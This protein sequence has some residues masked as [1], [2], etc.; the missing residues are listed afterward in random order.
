M[1]PGNPFDFTE[2]DIRVSIAARGNSLSV[3]AF[4]DGGIRWQ[5]RFTPRIPG[6]Y[7]VTGIT[8]NGKPIDAAGLTSKDAVVAKVVKPGFVGRDPK[9]PT[10]LIHADG[11]GY[12]PVGHNVAWASGSLTIPGALTK[13]GAAGENWS[14]VWMCHWSQ[15]N[16]DWGQPGGRLSLEIAR[17]WDSIV[18]TAEKQGNL[19]PDDASAPR[20][21][22]VECE[23]Q[24]GREPLECE[25]RGISQRPGRI[26]RQ[27]QS[28]RAHQAQ[29]SV[30]FS[31]LGLLAVGSGLGIVQR[32]GMVRWNS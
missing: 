22:F 27:S 6:A 21:V 18:S 19:L 16:L 32:S 5:A 7:K 24:L 26:F 29:V 13:M 28:D 31:S 12:Y 4:F 23:F 8:R 9:N 30:Y 3:P 2:N 17:T 20:P 14:R 1:L 15:T 11:S 25:K 10:R